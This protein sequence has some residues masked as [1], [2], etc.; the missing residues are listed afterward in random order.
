V[1]PRA[2]LLCRTFPPMVGGIERY[3]SD[4][5]Q[6]SDVDAVAV[7]PDHP[8]ADACDAGLR[9]EVRRYPFPAALQSGKR[10]LAAMAPVALAAALRHRPT[11]VFSDQVQTAAVGVPLARMLGVPHVVFAYGMELSP[12][13]LRR[14]KQWALDRSAAVVSIS[15]FTSARLRDIYGVDDARIT[16]VHPGVD[17]ERFATLPRAARAPDGAPVLLT[18]GRLDASQ[19]YKGYDRAVRA[20]AALRDEFP[21]LTL[22]V[23]GRGDDQPRLEALASTLGV[24][25][26][27]RF[28]GFVPDAEL[29]ALYRRADVFLL[30][31]GSP[32]VDALNV[33]GYGIVFA[34]AAASGVPS[35]AYR[36]GGVTDAVVDGETGFLTAPEEPALHDALRRLLRDGALRE[37]LGSAARRHAERAL[38][39]RASVDN[40]TGLV[41]AL[42]GARDQWPVRA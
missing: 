32:D 22:L 26:R 19:P 5:F 28:L 11:V 25:D 21:A 1:T 6:R 27:V 4:L 42:H 8:D 41:A 9:Y 24:A 36:L 29:P 17:V 14:F 40:F 2:L 3:V 16:M 33:E 15:R 12:L 7:A 30:P 20:V 10:P 31:S 35:I 34:E 23:A 39:W 37:R 18:V 13:R 38:A